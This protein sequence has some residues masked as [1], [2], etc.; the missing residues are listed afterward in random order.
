MSSHLI[1]LV[2]TAAGQS[3]H[4]HWEQEHQQQ[5]PSNCQQDKTNRGASVIW[6]KSPVEKLIQLFVFFWFRQLSGTF[7]KR[8][9]WDQPFCLFI[10]RLAV[11][12]PWI[13]QWISPHH[14]ILDDYATYGGHFS[15]HQLYTNSASRASRLTR[16]MFVVEAA[17]RACKIAQKVT[18][19]KSQPNHTFLLEGI[20]ASCHA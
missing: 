12:I 2:H 11:L 17:S 9:F 18:G 7:R 16:R 1:P 14:E 10:E 13:I 6:R 3:Q 4:T 8:T 5:A 20:H 19:Q 15:R